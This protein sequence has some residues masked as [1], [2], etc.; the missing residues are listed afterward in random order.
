MKYKHL[1]GPLRSRRLGISLGIDLTPGEICTMNC[2]YCECGRT[3][4]L[5]DER[6]E[7]VPTRE[8]IAELRDFLTPGPELDSITFSGSGEPT[9]HAGIGEIIAF[10]KADFPRY[11]VTVITN[12]SLLHLPEVRAALLP[13]DR[14]MPS[15]DAVTQDA[16]RK[17]NRPHP[18]V[19]LPEMVH[20]LQT[21]CREYRGEVWLEIFIIPGINDTPVELD[22]FHEILQHLQLDRTQLNTLDRAGTDDLE[23]AS[24]GR[25]EEIAHLL[26]PLA[27]VI[28]SRRVPTAATE[29]RPEML[30]LIKHTLALSPLFI[31]QI[32]ERVGLSRIELMPYLDELIK[33]QRIVATH[34]GGQ[35]LYRGSIG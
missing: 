8:V 31:G 15:L 23:P 25:L 34:D 21:F 12:S 11:R 22:A 32:V 5:T 18:A 30:D 16:F 28:A 7:Y 14:I 10:L 13:A 29:L 20:G 17:I 6:R 33:T 3:A 26:G 9:L 2:S 27:E 19:H 24:I 4:V 35:P 1:F